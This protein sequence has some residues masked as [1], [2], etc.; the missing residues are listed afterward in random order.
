MTTVIR[1]GNKVVIRP[2]GGDIVAACVP[3]LRSQMR[4]IVEQGVEDLVVDLSEVHMVDSCGIGLLI[5]AHNSLRKAGGRLAV[6]HASA[7]LLDLFQ[8]MRMHQHFSISGN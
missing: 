1:E 3:E 5:S 7:E 6:V 8:T 4:N 2:V